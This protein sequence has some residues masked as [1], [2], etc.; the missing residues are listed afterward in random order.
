MAN[1]VYF[2]EYESVFI[3]RPDVD[4]ATIDQI[5]ERLKNAIKNKGGV[6][7]KQENWGKRRL[8]YPI[9]KQTSG[10][11]VLL[12]F[13]G[14]SGVVEELERNYKMIEQVIRFM[15]IVTKDKV[16]PEDV[17]AGGEGSLVGMEVTGPAEA[18]FRK[19]GEG[20]ESAAEEESEAESEESAE[21]SAEQTESAEQEAEE[22][23]E[24][25]AEEVEETDKEREAE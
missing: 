22:G 16:R 21:E 18:D 15:T 23:S 13:A 1:V 6:I 14:P 24:E 4:D 17:V 10:H 20:H 5:V 11:Y 7:I 9:K 3:L 25:Q 8:A 19:R 12:L 2:R